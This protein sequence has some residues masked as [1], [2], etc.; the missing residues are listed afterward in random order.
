LSDSSFLPLFH[1]DYLRA[2]HDSKSSTLPSCGPVFPSSSKPVVD[3]E[4][5]LDCKDTISGWILQPFDLRLQ[6]SN[7]ILRLCAIAL[8]TLDVFNC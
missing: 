7:K 1:E 8:K 5:T 3:L 6:S 2:C 4:V